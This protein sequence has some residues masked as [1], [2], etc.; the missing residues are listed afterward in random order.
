MIETIT[1]LFINWTEWWKS[2]S[3]SIYLE[4]QDYLRDNKQ[5][6]PSAFKY[7]WILFCAFQN[8]IGY[9][10]GKWISRYPY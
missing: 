7:C 8:W 4:Y 5:L 6:F 9:K 1:N 10:I 3:R 2:I